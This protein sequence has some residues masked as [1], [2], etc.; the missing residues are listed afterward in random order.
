LPAWNIRLILFSES[1]EVSATIAFPRALQE[2]KSISCK[3]GLLE[4]I[5]DPTE[6]FNSAGL[7]LVTSWCTGDSNGTHHTRT[8]N[9]RNATLA[10]RTHLGC[11][12]RDVGG[13]CD[14]ARQSKRQSSGKDTM[15]EILFC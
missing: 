7:I 2:T 13:N 14:T 6:P 15:Q 5:P 11:E 12:N 8:R 1:K 10:R 3:M 9:N 4:T